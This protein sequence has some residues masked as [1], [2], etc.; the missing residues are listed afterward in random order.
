MLLPAVQMVREA[1]RRTQC[2][3]NVR[4]I[5]LATMNFESARMKFPA[6]W[7]LEESKQEGDPLIVN[8][9]PY[10]FHQGGIVVGFCDGSVHFIAEDISFETYWNLVVPNDGRVLGDF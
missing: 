6:G 10:S 3:N 4:Q 2:T 8:H 9:T 5:S 7:E 1:A